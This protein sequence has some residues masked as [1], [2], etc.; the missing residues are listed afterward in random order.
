MPLRLPTRTDFPPTLH[1]HIQSPPSSSPRP[2]NILLLL[3]GLGDTTLPFQALGK[4]L[5]LPETVCISLQAPTP[6]PFSL[7]GF[8]WGDD[9]AFSRSTGEMDPDSGFDKAL[10]MIKQEVIEAALVGKCGYTYREIITFGLGQGGSAALAVAAAIS[11]ELG[12]VVSLGGPLPSSS[13]SSSSSRSLTPILVL[14]GTSDT[15]ITKSVLERIKSGFKHVEYQKW[16]RA[17]DGMP[18][19]REEMMPIMRFF[20]RRL[21]SWKGVPEGSVEVG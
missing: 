21:R 20:A 13:S 12:G 18:K 7:G 17:G 4:Q 3:H 10:K 16:Q 19:N 5:S 14:A 9:I 2:T 6:L 8:H 11:Q 15:M 1:L